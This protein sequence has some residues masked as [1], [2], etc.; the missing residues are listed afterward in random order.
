MQV[1]SPSHMQEFGAAGPSGLPR[2]MGG[3]AQ[4]LL[5][6]LLTTFGLAETPMQTLQ[7]LGSLRRQ[8]QGAKGSCGAAGGRGAFCLPCIC[9][10]FLDGLRLYWELLPS[11]RDGRWLKLET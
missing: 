3:R 8:G 2:V 7:G 9:A 6:K 11:R 5:P 1:W 10:S 4:L